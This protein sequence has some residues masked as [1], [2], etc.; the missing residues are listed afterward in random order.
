[1]PSKAAVATAAIN[2]QM[3]LAKSRPRIRTGWKTKLSL[4][5]A[6]IRYMSDSIVKT[7][8]KRSK[9]IMAGP[10]PVEAIIF[11]TKTMARKAVTNYL[12]SHIVSILLRYLAID[13][14]Q[15]GKHMTNLKATKAKIKCAR[16]HDS[17]CGIVLV[18][19]NC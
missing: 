2:N 14:Q 5:V 18:K 19:R 7:A 17:G 4:M 13:W 1:M 9:L 15:I 10:F 12:R 3:V 8:A 6:M 16:N 11:A